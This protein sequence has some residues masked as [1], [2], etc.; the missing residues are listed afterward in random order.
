MQTF[1]DPKDGGLDVGAVVLV[2]GEGVTAED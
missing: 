2:R 1:A